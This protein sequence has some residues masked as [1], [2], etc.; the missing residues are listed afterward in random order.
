[1]RTKIPIIMIVQGQRG[2]PRDPANRI[3]YRSTALQMQSHRSIIG[4]HDQKRT[5][6]DFSRQQY[7]T[8]NA[9]LGELSHPDFV[10]LLSNARNRA[11]ELLVIS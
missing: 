11:R 9:K 10:S 2:R 5:E 3:S 1:M 8:R 6:A 4:P 7:Q